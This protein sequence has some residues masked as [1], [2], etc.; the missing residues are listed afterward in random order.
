MKK[1]TAWPISLAVPT[2]QTLGGLAKSANSAVDAQGSISLPEKEY[3]M[4][5]QD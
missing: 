2:R 5:N 4:S 3:E 1:A